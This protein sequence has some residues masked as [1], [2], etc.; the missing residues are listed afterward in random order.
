MPI[1]TCGR[2]QQP[3]R[4]NPLHSHAHWE[5]ILNLEGTGTM[6]IAAHIYP[7]FPGSV[8]C[9]PPHTEHSKSPDTTFQDIYVEHSDFPY[10][11]SSKAICFL[12]DSQ[13]TFENLL[14]ILYREFSSGSAHCFSVAETL[15]G[16]I[17]TLLLR[18]CPQSDPSVQQLHDSLSANFSDP[19]FTVSQAMSAIPMSPDHLRKKF[20]RTYG[21]T[22]VQ[23]L[24]QLKINRAKQLLLSPISQQLTVEE[25]SFLCG[26]SDSQYFRRLFR[27]QTQ[28][29]PTGYATSISSQSQLNT[30]E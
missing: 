25:I 8:I 16:I 3:L 4:A 7:F 18:H 15:Y 19:A 6:D 23:Y 20:H 2:T 29:S 21:V 5:I 9:I 27:K 12:D 26:F 10:G 14:S 28:H 24:N 30:K 22:P 11:A 13:R 1:V 17:E